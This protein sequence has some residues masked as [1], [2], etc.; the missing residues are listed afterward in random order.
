AVD[1][2]G[3]VIVVGA[4][5]SAGEIL[6]Q[7]DYFLI[8]YSKNGNQVLWKKDYHN[9]LSDVPWRLTIDEQTGNIFVTGVTIRLIVS[10]SATSN[11]WTIK[12]SGSNGE[13]LEEHALDID[14]NADMGLDVALTSDRKVV[15]TGSTKLDAP[16]YD[17][18]AT[19]RYTSNLV[20]EGNPFFYRGENANESA[21]GL[22]IDSND[23][24][25]VT[26]HTSSWS[27]QDFLTVKYDET[28]GQI[29]TDLRDVDGVKN[30]AL[31]IAVDVADNVIITGYTVSE[32][33]RFCTIKYDN[34]LVKQWIQQEDF[35][36]EAKAVA[37]D[38]QN[39][40]IVAGYN[41]ERD[42][43]YYTIK[44][45]PTGSIIWQG[46]GGSAPSQPPDASFTGPSSAY[47]GQPVQ[48]TDTSTGT[49][50]SRSWDF[51]DES[52]GSGSTT[53]HTY[54]SSG[55][56]T[57]KLTVTGA[58]ESDSATKQI[59]VTNAPPN[60]AFD[61][62]PLAPTVD[63]TVSFDAADSYDPYGGSIASYNWDFGDGSSGSSEMTT[64]IY[65]E[66]G[67]YQ[68]TLTV[69]D[70]DGASASTSKMVT[71]NAVG[72]HAPTAQF[73]YKPAHPDVNE[74]VTFD[75]SA[76]TDDGTIQLY[77]WDWDN[78]G[79][80]DEE[81]AAAT[82]THSWPTAGTYTVTLEVEDNNGTVNTYT[83]SITVGG[84]DPAL[85]ISGPAELQEKDIENGVATVT[86]SVSCIN[87][88]VD[89]VY[90]DIEEDAGAT[91]TVTPQQARIQAGSDQSFALE[92]ELPDNATA[93][94][95]TFRAVGADGTQS[96][97]HSIQIEGGG[98]GN[99]GTPG[100]AALLAIAAIFI[101]LLVMRRFR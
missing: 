25:F 16:Y 89:G 96:A 100:F 17:A 73:D 99:G 30:S 62:A 52:S 79:T 44:Y 77:R 81:R 82:V 26:G 50:S 63:A 38:S 67:T 64:H 8:K 72:S 1:A 42:N 60:P 9:G 29:K 37:V 94:A 59:T 56:Y 11:F 95:I 40:V 55:T 32:G 93:D 3:N 90:I 98:D 58:G 28:G 31:D 43:Q 23:N 65:D 14:D 80:Y 6:P 54:S 4:I 35:L 12:C 45:S 21:S 47:V 87:Q 20:P 49:V 22:A 101:V 10:E 69:M 91:I 53:T 61:Y 36:G 88:T 57:V 70:A 92:I 46:G 15:V 27:G 24:I 76:S 83:A 48:F 34:N 7:M 41:T 97:L 39:N 2:S 68:V 71:V 33:S 18:Y 86:I 84:G 51:G 5:G 13:L 19:Q 78:D 66:S 85:V 74:E 75:A